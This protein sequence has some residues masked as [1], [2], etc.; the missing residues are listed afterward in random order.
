MVSSLHVRC[1]RVHATYYAVCVRDDVHNIAV[2][3]GFHNHVEEITPG[4]VRYVETP[5]IAFY[6]RQRRSI[7]AYCTREIAV[8]VLCLFESANFLKSH[9]VGT[10]PFLHGNPIYQRLVDVLF[11]PL[12]CDR[13]DM[14]A[15]FEVLHGGVFRFVEY[16]LH[17][18]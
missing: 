15:A 10:H 16:L 1:R 12:A 17:K 8:C 5:S 18:R 11:G 6:R 14:D 3:I 9:L 4:D 13:D 7:G 2:L